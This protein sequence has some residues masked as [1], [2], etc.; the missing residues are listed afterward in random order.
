MMI[1][2]GWAHIYAGL[3]ALAVILIVLWK[4]NKNLSYLFFFSIFWIYLMGAARVVAFPFP[5]DLSNPNFKPDLNLIPFDFG[6]CHPEMLSQ[7]IQ[8]LYEN[9]LL[10]IPFGL[11]ISFI[12]RIK[13]NDSLWLALAVGFTF[14]FVQF[15]ISLAVRSSFRVV[16]INDVILNATGVLLGYGLFN[17]FGWLYLFVIQKLNLQPKYIFAYFHNVLLPHFNN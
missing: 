4:R 13:P 3:A 6:Y 8:N 2:F 1:Y 5:I 9:I 7:C 15:V 14:E 11:G 17:I 12:T 10:T 16:D